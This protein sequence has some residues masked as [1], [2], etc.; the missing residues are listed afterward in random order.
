M[1]EV[2]R[3]QPPQV[4]IHTT[5]TQRYE[6]AGAIPQ[7]LYEGGVKSLFPERGFSATQIIAILAGVPIGGMLLFLASASLI[8]SLVGL[9]VVTPLFILF[10]PVLVPAA[11]TIGLA[12]AGIL[13]SEACGLM[14]LMSFSWVMNYIRQTQ[15]TVPEQLDSAKRCMADMAGYVGQKTKDVGQ[16][17][18][19]VGQ[20]IQQKAHE[21]KRT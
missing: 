20:D 2:L 14:G 5:T 6:G 18:K 10:S 1:A 12:V 16:K 21:A 8:V 7:H 17:T 9:A 13:A 19:D 4:Q 15:G 3:S 11:I